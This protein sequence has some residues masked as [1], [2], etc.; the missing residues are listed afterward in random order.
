MRERL[1]SCLDSP[2][3]VWAVASVTFTQLVRM[4]IFWIPALF[5]VLFL[6]LQGVHYRDLLGPDV[7]GTAELLF[8]KNTAV[9]GIRLFGLL[10][11][12]VASAMMV[13]RDTED[14][15][16]YTILGKSVPCWN[17]LAGKALGVILVL[18]SVLVLL[19]LMMVCV[20][21]H[22]TAGVVAEQ[23][24]YLLNNGFKADELQPIL[25]TLREQGATWNLQRSFLV[26]FEEWCVLVSLT[27]L[28][29]CFTSGSIVSMFFSGG[30]YLIGSFQDQ[31]FQTLTTG[32][33]GLSDWVVKIGDLFALIV[34]NFQAFAVFDAGVNGTPLSW[35]IVGS[36]CLVTVAY[37][38]FHTA[39][40][41]WI[42]SKK[43]F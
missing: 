5:A 17:Y 42:F 7:R 6:L 32:S 20:L 24:H 21:E 15:I 11:A 36:L 9:G 41:S 33:G 4:K 23:T 43:E 22:R 37:F 30:F 25:D 8:I 18:G 16:L 10:V 26:M 34:P 12:I 13:S 35:G 31:L 1:Q 3:R 39:I 28:F 29:S 14:R 38:T 19:D 40:A 2:R 27:I